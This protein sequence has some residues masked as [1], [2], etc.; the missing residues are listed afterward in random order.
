VSLCTHGRHIGCTCPVTNFC[1]NL[2]ITFQFVFVTSS[3]IMLFH[4]Q[5]PKCQ[6]T[7]HADKSESH[8]S[9]SFDSVVV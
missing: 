3:C 7:R 1:I 6:A 4:F 8:T 5:V 9:I 2:C